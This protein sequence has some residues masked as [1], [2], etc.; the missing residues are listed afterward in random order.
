MAAFGTTAINYY[1]N[2]ADNGFAWNVRYDLSFLNSES[3]TTLKVD[4]V[5]DNPGSM[6]SVWQNG[7]NDIWN[8]KAFFSD[9]SRL[10]EVKMDFSFVDSGAHHTVNVHAGTGGT[11]M[12][13]WYLDSPSG[14]PNSM[15]DEIAAHETGHMFGLFDE[16]AGGGTYNGYTTTGTL[17]SDLTVSGFD[18]YSWPQE[19]YTEYYGGMSLSRLLGKTGTASNDTLTGGSGMDGFYGLGGNDT[20]SG[21]GGNDFLDGGTGRDILTGGAGADIFDYDRVSDTGN[22]STSRDVIKDFVHLTDDIDLAGMDASSIL[23]GNNAFVWR[24][25]GGITTSTQGELRY[26]KY[27]NTGTTNDYTVLYGDTDGDTA[28]EFQIQLSG[29]VTLSLS[30]LLV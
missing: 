30:D 9:G 4:L 6:A 28:S 5:G 11:N 29:L 16:Y 23:S 8:N 14:W 17:M 26:Q 19:Y 22:T 7:V 2:R 1:E 20:I 15:Q 13:N 12:T 18:Y 27:D 24:G 3:L 10:Y 25:T 21:S